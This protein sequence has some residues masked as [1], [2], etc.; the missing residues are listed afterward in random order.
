MWEKEGADAAWVQVFLLGSARGR[1]FREKRQLLPTC[2]IRN[3]KNPSLTLLWGLG[4]GLLAPAGLLEKTLPFRSLLG[5]SNLCLL[6][7]S[8]G[9]ALSFLCPLLTP[10]VSLHSSVLAS[11]G[12]RSGFHRPA[13]KFQNAGVFWLQNCLPPKDDVPVPAVYQGPQ[14]QHRL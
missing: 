4:F 3:D 13:V 6:C 10:S 9:Q 5:D 14:Q 12:E 11:G 1:G 2:S 7:H 8:S